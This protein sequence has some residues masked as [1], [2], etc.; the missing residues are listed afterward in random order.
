M[1]N[2]MLQRRCSP[3]RRQGQLPGWQAAGKTGTSQD[4]R[5]AWFIGYTSQLVT[6]VWLG[7]DDNS[8]TKRAS[9]ANL[10]VEIWSRY[11][12][13]ALKGMVVAGLPT[14]GSRSETL[15]GGPAASLWPFSPG[16]GNSA[17]SAPAPHM[18]LSNPSA[19]VEVDVQ[20]NALAMS[21]RRLSSATTSPFRRRIFPMVPRP[22][23]L[24]D[25]KT[26]SSSFLAARLGGRLSDMGA[27][28]N[29][30]P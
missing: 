21:S 13:E 14:G 15:S 5:D 28:A 23:G 12:R 7:N 30:A 10:P 19:P 2:A 24:P 27:A 26:S 22:G 29:A 16:G 4:C 17:P 6:G 25:R 8:P 20:A 9:G 11:M 18:D 1:M 3:A